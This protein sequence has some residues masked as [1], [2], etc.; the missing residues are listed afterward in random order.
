MDNSLP[1]RKVSP[2]ELTIMTDRDNQK[3]RIDENK[4]IRCP[5]C[6]K[7]QYFDKYLANNQLGTLVCCSCGVLFIDQ[8]KLKLIKKD[9]SGAKQKGLAKSH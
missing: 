2:E 4:K 1:R 8:A 6:K 9:I 7:N 5:C 3:K